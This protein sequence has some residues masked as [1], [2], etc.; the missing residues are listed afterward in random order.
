MKKPTFYLVSLLLAATVCF[1][2]ESKQADPD[3]SF[4]SANETVDGSLPIK[5]IIQDEEVGNPSQMMLIRT[6]DQDVEVFDRPSTDATAIGKCRPNTLLKYRSQRT[7]SLSEKINGQD[8]AGQ[9]LYVSSS[10]PPLEGWIFAVVDSEG[11]N[12]EILVGGRIRSWAIEEGW[13]FAYVDRWNEGKVNDSLKIAGLPAMKHGY[14]GYYCFLKS[15][16]FDDLLNGPFLVVAIEN[17]IQIDVYGSFYLGKH[18]GVFTAILS[19][20]DGY[21]EIINLDYSGEDERCGERKYTLYNN[22]HFI[23]FLFDYKCS[24][25]FSDFAI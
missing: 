15:E 18:S 17:G 24:F 3:K 20:P 19:R 10:D 25:D 22:K 21:Q 7:D 6:R 9:W 11:E 2:C 14:T 16:G 1:S 4:S 5:A 12:T 13:N 8:K 23:R